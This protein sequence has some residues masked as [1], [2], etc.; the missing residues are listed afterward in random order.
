MYYHKVELLKEASL[1]I[2][3]IRDNKARRKIIENIEK[4]KSTP[5][6][7]PKIYKKVIGTELYEFRT[8]YNRMQYRLFSFKDGN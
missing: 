3:K 6:Q 7:D 5:V 1:F 2:N 4:V 8:R